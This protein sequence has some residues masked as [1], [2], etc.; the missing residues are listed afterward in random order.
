M[1]LQPFPH[2]GKFAVGKW[3]FI[4]LYLKCKHAWNYS[5]FLIQS[6]STTY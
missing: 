5:S 6:C 4:L 3:T 1:L 2:I